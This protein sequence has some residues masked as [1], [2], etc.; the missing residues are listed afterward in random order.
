M[1]VV[2]QIPV[3]RGLAVKN[4]RP[5]PLSEEDFNGRSEWVLAKGMKAVGDGAFE[6]ETKAARRKPK[7]ASPQQGAQ[8]EKERWQALSSAKEGRHAQSKRCCFELD[9]TSEEGDDMLVF[10]GTGHSGP[11]HS[12]VAFPQTW[13]IG[14]R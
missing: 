14:Q 8:R 3:L 11:R 13:E 9:E 7:M 4:G 6:G 12:C 10:G 5:S 2:T 1:R